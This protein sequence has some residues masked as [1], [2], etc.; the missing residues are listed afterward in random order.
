[1]DR[2][3]YAQYIFLSFMALKWEDQHLPQQKFICRLMNIIP[4]HPP[5]YLPRYTLQNLGNDLLFI[6]FLNVRTWKT[7]SEKL[8][9][10]ISLLCRKKV[11][12][13]VGY[14]QALLAT[15]VSM[16]AIEFTIWPE[17][18]VMKRTRM[19]AILGFKFWE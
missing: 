7:F 18:L 15:T 17:I 4:L 3:L 5:K 2:C 14:F 6:P 12:K 13:N 9:Q 16:L 10:N 1:M 19:S 8:H 11:M